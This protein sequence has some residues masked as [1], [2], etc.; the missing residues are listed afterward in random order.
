MTTGGPGWASGLP[1]VIRGCWQLSKGHGPEWSE[2]S[3]TRALDVAQASAGELVLDMGD[4]YTGVE[5]LV[6]VWLGA[7][8][9]DAAPVRVHS[10]FVPD[11]GVLDQVDRELVRGTVHRSLRRLGM[12]TLDLVQLHWWDFSVPGWAEATGWLCELQ[13][14]GDIRAVGVT[15]FDRVHL[16]QLL[17]SGFPIVSNQVQLSLLDRRPLAELVPLCEANDVALLCYGTLAGGLLTERWRG[18]PWPPA[19]AV[20]RSVDKYRLIVDEAGGWDALQH[21]LDAIASVAG[22]TGR[23]FAEIVAT[24]VRH[25]RAVA[26]VI[27][28][29]S[30]GGGGRTLAWQSPLTPLSQ[31]HVALLD[32]ALPHPFSGVVYEAE[33]DRN[34][35]HG[36]LM[37]YD[38][39]GSGTELSPSPP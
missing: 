31:E 25:Q 14:D 13:K 34:G 2:D 29:L 33:R 4:I 20:N 28:G 8:S 32:S 19:E 35:P 36:K 22:E 1:D 5:T 21:L 15:N 16:A 23:S 3:A 6:G 7:R 12:E 18:K 30:R 24:Y 9:D 39:A 37:H 17:E 27:L 38:L 10:K 11:L 26:S